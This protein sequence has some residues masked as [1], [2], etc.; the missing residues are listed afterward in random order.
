MEKINLI[1]V[2]LEGI[3]SFLSPCVIP[4][5]PVYISVLSNSKIDSLNEERHGFIKSSLFRNTLFFTLGISTTFFILG[6]SVNV[7]SN[8]LLVTKI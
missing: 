7:L 8:F 6:A 5:L 2:F 1:I 3:L 4:I